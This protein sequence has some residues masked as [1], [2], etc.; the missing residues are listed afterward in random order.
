MHYSHQ[1][2]KEKYREK[3]LI[4]IRSGIE[5]FPGAGHSLALEANAIN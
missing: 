1:I 3:V 2:G 4:Q 5:T